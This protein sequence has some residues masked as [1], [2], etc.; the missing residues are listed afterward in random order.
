[1]T[2][3]KKSLQED[4]NVLLADSFKGA[5]LE[6]FVKYTF[7]ESLTNISESATDE[8]KA[9]RLVNWAEEKGNLG[10]L[11]VY[12]AIR[13]EKKFKDFIHKHL[14]EILEISKPNLDRLTDFIFENLEVDLDKLRTFIAQ[15]LYEILKDSNLH[16][17]IDRQIFINLLEIILQIENRLNNV[18]LV[19]KACVRSVPESG[20][21]DARQEMKD[22]NNHLLPSRYRFYVLIKVLEKYPPDDQV[23]RIFRF[24]ENLSKENQ[25]RSD[26]KEKL[27]K[28]LPDKLFPPVNDLPSNFLERLSKNPKLSNGYLL[29]EIRK[30]TDFKKEKFHVN[31]FLEY[32]ELGKSVHRSVDLA[33]SPE[34]KSQKGTSCSYQSLA[35]IVVKLI[36]LGEEQFS[37]EKGDAAGPLILEFFLPYEYLTE[38]IDLWEI[39]LLKD[40]SKPI[41][42]QY[43]IILR[44]SDR[45]ESHKL[46]PRLKQSWNQLESLKRRKNISK[47]QWLES[48]LHIEGI[49]FSW[50]QDIS[51]K[52]GIKLTC[53][54]PEDGEKKATLISDVLLTN[55]PVAIWTRSGSI[56]E[57]PNLS[58]ALDQFL[59]I[60]HFRDVSTLLKCIQMERA[61]SARMKSPE[62]YLGHHIAFLYDDPYRPLPQFQPLSIE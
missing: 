62:K 3:F 10:D 18:E 48:F 9:F 55:L 43:D 14:E 57:S 47:R 22:L 15:H 19:F 58:E 16:P 32:D 21:E 52:I 29:I 7:Q 61:K 26:L 5:D 59:K 33:D 11:I 42:S 49:D 1:M 39:E 13:K 53:G 45:M 38:K 17:E 25:I 51:K 24:I 46:L 31:A 36:H 4:L 34:E 50:E 54:L 20:L 27:R 37:A 41:G 28:L 35:E 44:S 60:E 2:N 40:V 23:P 56:S 6:M 12:A 30:M 8:V